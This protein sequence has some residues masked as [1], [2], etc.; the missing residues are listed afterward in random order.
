MPTTGTPRPDAHW[1]HRLAPAVQSRLS[2]K[3][4]L[5]T[6]GVMQMAMSLAE[7][8]GEDLQS[9]GTAALLHD[10]A[11]EISCEELGA[12]ID[13]AGWKHWPLD[14]E[15]RGLWHAWAGEIIA[16]DELAIRDE[17]ILK[18][19]R[20]HSTGHPAMGRLEMIIFLSDHA[21]SGRGPRPDLAPVR[22]TARRDLEAAVWMALRDKTRYLSNKATLVTVHPWSLAAFAALD[23]RRPHSATITSSSSVVS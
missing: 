5:H 23:A 16:R 9:A 6:N 22:A 2:T 17:S 21:E 7:L 8:Y 19:I 3:R 18:A 13:R 20:H 15:Y 4:W 11:K 10:L 14:D 12:I 1:F